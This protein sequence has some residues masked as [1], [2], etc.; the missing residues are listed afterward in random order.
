MNFLI[1]WCFNSQECYFSD[2]NQWRNKC[3]LFL[4]DLGKYNYWFINFYNFEIDLNVAK[5]WVACNDHNFVRRSKMVCNKVTDK[6]Y[7]ER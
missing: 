6:S 7:V 2:L 1:N 3:H 4:R 5:Y